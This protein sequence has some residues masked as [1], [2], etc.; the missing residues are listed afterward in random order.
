MSGTYECNFY[1]GEI[2]A[3]AIDN[4]NSTK[5]TNFGFGTLS[6]SD[7]RCGCYTGFYVTPMN[8]PTILKAIQFSTRNNLSDRDPITVSIEGTNSSLL[9]IGSSWTL[10]YSGSSGLDIDPG[11]YTLGV[12][13]I[14][15][16]TSAYISYRLLI[17][18]KRAIGTAVQYSE[19]VLLGYY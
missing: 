18:T 7:I 9:T 8:G 1:P 5:Y 17:I 13:Q 3:Y 4:N 15:N 10:I 12:Q 6:T 16:N 19:A 14:F 11:R 2:P